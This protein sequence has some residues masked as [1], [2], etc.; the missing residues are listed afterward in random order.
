MFL[1]FSSKRPNILPVGDLGSFSFLVSP[2]TLSLSLLL[3]ANAP[4]QNRHPK[5]PLPLVRRGPF[6]HS[7]HPR[8][9]TAE[10]DYHLQGR[11][12]RVDSSLHRRRVVRPSLHPR[13]TEGDKERSLPYSFLAFQLSCSSCRA[14]ARDG[15]ELGQPL[16]LP[17]YE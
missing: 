16:H 9:Q 11:R 15:E 4:S 14:R 8:S 10:S 6:F 13:S 12:T 2:S 1:I 17:P 7:R 3:T 5:S